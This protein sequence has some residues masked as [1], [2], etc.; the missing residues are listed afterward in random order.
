MAI[1]GMTNLQISKI[2]SS[3][4]GNVAYTPESTYY[5][6]V[7]TTPI[8]E[9]G[10]NATEPTDPSYSRIAIDNNL[11]NWESD[12]SGEGRQNAIPID[13]NVATVNQGTITYL[14]IWNGLTGSDVIY[15]SEL[16]NPKTVGIDDLLRLDVGSLIIKL[17]PTT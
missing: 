1:S 13:F 3:E 7:S 12:V 8:T 2:L 11:T 16:I 14:G 6:G 10:L 9:D 15:Y 17:L 5:I 4:F